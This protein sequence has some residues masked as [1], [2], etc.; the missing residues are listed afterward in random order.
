MM[1][2]IILKEASVYVK[3][4]DVHGLGLGRSSPIHQPLRFNTQFGKQCSSF[5]E[6]TRETHHLLFRQTFDFNPLKLA[7][8]LPRRARHKLRL[9][10]KLVIV[11]FH[12]SSLSSY[13]GHR[14]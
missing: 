10:V 11:V 8:H 13:E 6:V 9:S 1:R 4:A 14:V 5:E 3:S 2:C 7:R 12:I